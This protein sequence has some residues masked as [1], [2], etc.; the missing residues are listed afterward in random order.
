MKRPRSV[1]LFTPQTPREERARSPRTREHASRALARAN[2]KIVRRIVVLTKTTSEFLTNSRRDACC[3]PF[4]RRFRPPWRSPWRNSI[5]ACRAPWPCA[6]RGLPCAVAVRQTKGNS[7]H[8]KPRAAARRQ[9]IP[10]PF[11]APFP[12]AVGQWAPLFVRRGR[13]PLGRGV[14]EQGRSAPVRAPGPR[15]EVRP[16]VRVHCSVRM[17]C[18]CRAMI[19]PVSNLVYWEEAMSR[20][21]DT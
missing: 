13:A 1:G 2:G 20:S 4:V 8:T 3:G 6:A 12:C 18:R 16:L 10:P 9:G 14:H 11:R 21:A 19:F 7:G 17:A 5:G 15:R